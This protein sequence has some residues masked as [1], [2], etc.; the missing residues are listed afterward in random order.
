MA[1][2][3]D[4]TVSE[5]TLI[6]RV[7]EDKCADFTPPSQQPDDLH[8]CGK[9][10]EDRKIRAKVIRELLLGTNPEW[11]VAGMVWIKGARIDGELDLMG[12]TTSHGLRFESCCFTDGLNLTFAELPFCS[13]TNSAAKWFVA[14][15]L[16]AGS[17]SLDGTAFSS[18]ID[19]RSA[20]IAG[21][22]S[23]KD[24]RCLGVDPIPAL[25]AQQIRV[26]GSMLL[27]NL[28]ACGAVREQGAVNLS[29]AII[30]GQLSL[31]GAQIT[32]PAGPAIVAESVKVGT[33]VFLTGGVFCDE[34]SLIHAKIGGP[35]FCVGS[36]FVA[37][38]T[39]K[40]FV[41]DAADVGGSLQLGPPMG[42]NAPAESATCYIGL[43]RLP[44]A[45]I[46]DNL[47]CD[48]AF[49]MLAVKLSAP[50]GREGPPEVL[51]AHGV[52]VR[53]AVRFREANLCGAV[54]LP[55]AK[56]G[57][58]LDFAGAKFYGSS[59]LVAEHATV[60]GRF[61]WTKISM[62]PDTEL[63]LLDAKVSILADDEQ[64]WPNK[65][66]LII[67]GLIYGRVASDTRFN[68]P[69][70]LASRLDWLSRQPKFLSGQY[71]QFARWLRAE[72]R[73]NDSRE[74]L[75]A[76][77][78]QRRR[79]LKPS[80]S[81]RLWLSPLKLIACLIAY[82]W[83]LILKWTIAYGYKPGRAVWV[84]L[85]VI[86]FWSL[87]IWAGAAH[88]LMFPTGRGSLISLNSKS[89]EQNYESLSPLWYSADVF[90]PI[91][92]FRQEQSWWPSA[93]EVA[94]V[95]MLAKAAYSTLGVDCAFFPLDRDSTR[96]GP[97]SASR[98]WSYRNRA[99]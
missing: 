61:L 57:G 87:I 16:K 92:A 79:A 43:V 29:G 24:T 66:K 41:A 11:R 4:L 90:L 78:D 77:E 45:K 46:G 3:L 30:E 71:Q 19:V 20:R 80:R 63:D 28:K 26:E 82:G 8:Q 9:W 12:I 37:G 76:K 98:R 52:E 74:I 49:F 14:Q 60:G 97:H 1:D 47:D 15:N 27:Q 40:A 13:I 32:N 38:L 91:H 81:E 73:D 89:V 96:L 55:N 23:C 18:I 50:A 72:G 17:L 31:Q 36:R 64:S 53:G 62:S 99:S 67:D 5:K 83:L 59:G 86:G 25:N 34:V 35:V 65:E 84:S 94:L 95:L 51:V 2:Q 22:F 48:R 6:K 42:G 44:R 33:S 85:C 68:I 69:I 75:I 56:I 58:D 88:G 54:A 10:G 7:G 39:G 70:D 21:N 93:D